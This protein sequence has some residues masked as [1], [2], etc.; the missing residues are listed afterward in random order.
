MTII[1]RSKS[2]RQR[3][4]T[5][6]GWG[7]MKKHRGAGHRGG[8]GRA[9]SGKRGD[10][11]KPRYWKSKK[12]FGKFGFKSKSR[13]PDMT[14]I[15]LKTIDDRIES[16]V[17]KG[18]AK[19]DNGTYTLNLSDIGYNK[20]LSTGKVTRKLIITTDFATEKAVDKVKKA[21]GEVNII[22]DNQK[23]QSE[24]ENAETAVNDSVEPAKSTKESPEQTV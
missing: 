15:N 13:V 14:P 20:L 7:S 12:T 21:G 23:N 4:Y 10:Q 24:D 8:R 11:K 6:H 18:V 16:L 9:G 19:L 1:K 5:T 17:I 22:C 2:S 3:G